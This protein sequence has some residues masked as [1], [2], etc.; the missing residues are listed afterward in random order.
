LKSSETTALNE[1]GAEGNC[2]KKLTKKQNQ[3]GETL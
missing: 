3:T 2:Q 1:N